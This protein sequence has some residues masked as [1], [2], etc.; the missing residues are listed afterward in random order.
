MAKRR[1]RGS[2]ALEDDE[3]AIMLQRRCRAG[4]ALEADEAAS[5]LAPQPHCDVDQNALILQIAHRIFAGRL[6]DMYECSGDGAKTSGAQSALVMARFSRAVTAVKNGDYSHLD[7]FI[8]MQDGVYSPMLDGGIHQPVPGPALQPLP[9]S[10]GQGVL[11]TE[12]DDS[13]PRM[14]PVIES[15]Q[16]RVVTPLGL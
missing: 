12:F 3:A 9:A 2:P 6:R 13:A 1:Y 7:E 11:M 4:Q 8:A 5:M 14:L 10:T 15:D 16:M